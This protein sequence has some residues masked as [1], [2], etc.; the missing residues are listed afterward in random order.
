VR[1]QG[2][3][4]EYL[5]SQSISNPSFLGFNSI[6][7]IMITASYNDTQNHRLGLTRGFTDGL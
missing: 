3:P 6:N 2:E 1:A 7:F 5:H 4:D